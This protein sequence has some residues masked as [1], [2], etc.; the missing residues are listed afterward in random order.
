MYSFLFVQ[1][2]IVFL[3]RYTQDHCSDSQS[4]LEALEMWTDTGWEQDLESVTRL[5]GALNYAMPEGEMT[6]KNVRQ[7]DGKWK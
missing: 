7:R 6:G 5:Q 2:P 1:F 4:E 3:H